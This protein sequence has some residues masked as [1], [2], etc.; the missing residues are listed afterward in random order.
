MPLPAAARGFSSDIADRV[1]LNWAI[2]IDTDT[3]ELEALALVLAVLEVEL[4]EELLQ[5]A[6]ARLKASATDTASP[7]LATLIM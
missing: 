3:L 7:F 5:A 2:E 6:A 1:R 4:D